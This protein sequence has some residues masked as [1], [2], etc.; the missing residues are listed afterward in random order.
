MRAPNHLV[1]I[2]CVSALGLAWGAEPAATKFDERIA[3]I[4]VSRCLDCHSG[5]KPKGGLNLTRRQSAFDGG[6]HGPALV[7]GKLDES[8]LWDYIERDKMPPKKPLPAA[9][10]ALLREWIAGGAVWGTDPIDSFRTTTSARAGYDWW[11]LRPVVRPAPPAVKDGGWCR[12]GIDYFVLKRLES[13]GLAPSSE[14]DRR[15]LLRRLHFDLVGLP[16][17]PEEVAAFLADRAPDAYERAVDRLLASPAYG[18]RWARHWLDVARYGESNGFEYDEFRAA[19]WPYRDWVV[20]ALNQD[21]PYDEF[22][23]LQL[24]GDVLRPEDPA[25]VKA[26]GFLVAGPYDTVGQTQ[27]S[28]AMRRVVRQ[29]ELEDLVGTV[30]QAFLGLTVNCARCH[31]HKFDPVRQAE[32]YRLTSAL[33]GVRHGERE[34]GQLELPVRN[35]Q[36]R[37]KV[38]DTEVNAIETPIRQKILDERRR[39]TPTPPRPIARWDFTRDFKDAVGSLHAAPRGPV[40]RGEDGARFDGR[41]TYLLTAPLEKD[42][43]AKTLETWVRLSDLKQRGG[44][45]ISVQTKGGDGFDAIVFGEQESG[46][47]MPGSDGFRRT[48]SV[49]GPV[50]EEAD[51]SVVHVAITYADDGTIT[52]YRNGKLHG[53]SYKSAGV[54]TFKAGA[55]EV[56][57][58]LRHSP[59]GGNKMLAGVVREARLYDRALTAE[60]VAASAHSSSTV[61]T[62]EE[63]AAR[64]SAETK[65]RWDK[66]R[67]EA[68]AQRLRIAAVSRRV[69]AVTPR[70]PESPAR[71]LTRGNPEQPGDIV[72]AG[73]VAAVPGLKADFGL[74]PDAPEAE[75]RKRLAEWITDR[76]NPLFARVIVN[77]LWHH[78]FGVGIVDT[79]NDFGFNGGRPTH[80][81]LLDW[82]A[83]DLIEHGWSL[84]RLHRTIVTSATYRQS[85]RFANPQSAIR[86]PQSI[87][88]GNRL[89]WR[90]SPQRLEAETVRDA[91]LYV[92]GRL[93][94][95]MAGPG[96]REFTI[97]KAPGTTASRFTPIDPLGTEFDRRTLYR[98]W[99]RGSRNGLLE[100]FDCPDPSTTTPRRAVTT[101]P[102]QALAMMNN[103]LVLRLSDHLAARIERE[104]GTEVSAHVARAYL[105]A[106]G[107]QPDEAEQTAAAAVVREHGLPALARAIFNSNEFLY[108]D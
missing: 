87:D 67:A 23:R 28:L 103:V 89:L 10:K 3:P 38:I 36:A 94:P 8:L 108:V 49:Q 63:I 15:T 31:D 33:D 101:T 66:L 43:K 37:L 1:A 50:E 2:L 106:Y 48:Q 93:N 100:A 40:E 41:A 91:M 99:V 79:P 25:A 22:V 54:I 11:S 62:P 86:N 76:R 46:R 102:L 19:G 78:H 12:N 20:D 56:A 9:E 92:S 14:A 34:I 44:A 52:L 47:W 105:L 75:R 74:A 39:N 24:A 82:L 58:G 64:L 104:V 29:D 6:K 18:V 95:E 98:T 69:Y 90:K 32:Y 73:A 71:L 57:F 77:R 97:G 51:R 30:G 83:T 55:A 72:S 16:P 59:A 17:T 60:E 84:K 4:L 7:P 96:F 88:A 35:A 68:I 61:V 26:T 85:S 42:L 65:T 13:S 80:S 5:P 70:T 53:R 45:A 81:E 27:Q 107:R 21:M